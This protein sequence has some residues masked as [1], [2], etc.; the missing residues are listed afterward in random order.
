MATIKTAIS[1]P[2]DVFRQVEELA[3]QRSSSRSGVV[4]E[5]ITAYLRAGHFARLTESY[6]AAYADE[7]DE[8]READRRFFAEQWRATSKRLAAAGDAWESG[9]GQP[10]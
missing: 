5:A 7:S 10:G 8:D 9:D 4:V 1:L 2:E 6:D 3:R